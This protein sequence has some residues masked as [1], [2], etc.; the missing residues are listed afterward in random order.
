MH[1]VLATPLTALTNG[2]QALSPY[3]F[4]TIYNVKPLWGIGFDGTGQSVAI[5][6][7]TNIKM[8]DVATFRSTF[9]LPGN[10]TTVI[11]N[12]TD[13]GIVSAGEELEADWDV[14]RS[15]SATCR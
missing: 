12:A 1:Q 7:R 9:G 6:G 3:D 4:A 11:L 5:A 10:N 2:A 8:T 15:T 14:C 13:P